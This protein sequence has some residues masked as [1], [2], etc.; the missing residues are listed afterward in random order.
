MG[1]VW[2]AI[3][4]RYGV[5]LHVTVELFR[6][7]PLVIV[8]TTFDPDIKKAFPDVAEMTQ[9]LSVQELWLEMVAVVPLM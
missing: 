6:A 8:S 4:D 9:E 2:K 1:E 3:A 7:Q 5:E